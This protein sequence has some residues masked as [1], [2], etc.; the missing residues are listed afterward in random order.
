MDE[1]KKQVGRA[2]SRLTWQRFVALLVRM[3]FAAFVVTLVA[4]AIPKLRPLPI[5]GQTWSWS[6][7]IGSAA[8]AVIATAVWTLAT[9]KSKLEAAI[10]LDQRFGLKERV[11]STLTLS[12]DELQSDAGKALL[13]D[14]TRRVTQVEVSEKFRSQP[15]WWN[16]LPLAPA[17]AVF[18]VTVLIPDAVPQKSSTAVAS[19]ETK[20]RLDRTAESLKKKLAERKKRAEAQGLKE[21]SDVFSKIEKGVDD[22]KKLEDVDRKKAL[23]KLNNLA[24]EIKQRRDK[25]G[26]PDKMRK[27]FNQMKDLMSGPADRMNDAL[28]KGDMKKAISEIQQL[29]EKLKTEKLSKEDREKLGDQLKQMAEKLNQLSQAH[30]MAKEELKKQID[31]AMANGDRQK[32]G[33]LQNKLDQMNAQNNQM[34][35]LGQLAQKM[36]QASDAAKQGKGGEASQQMNAIAEQLSEMQAEISEMAMLDAA[37]EE[38][39]SSKDSMNCRQCQGEGCSEC[40]GMG[41]SRL[42]GRGDGQGM[43]EGQGEGDRPESA[44]ANQFYD[45]KVKAKVGKG[46]AVVTGVASGPNRTGPALEEY[47]EAI[48]SAEIADEDPLTGAR[49][50]KEHREQATEYFNRLREGE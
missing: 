43:G 41:S 49:I 44:T 3:L 14:A 29:G 27:Q 50:P 31:Q 12:D 33:K 46:K 39:E 45:S 38:L 28:R 21:A 32:A 30:Q 36:S 23:V 5:D 18:L 37:L 25:I 26:D 42:A 11:S 9:R 19:S 4:A 17:L 10:E 8:V 15:H 34:S 1:L 24:D 48:R 22:M 2:H 6:W 20:Q 35:K 13:D 47:K 16:L 7:F 40:S